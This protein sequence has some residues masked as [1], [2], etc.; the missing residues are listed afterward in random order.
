MA[1]EGLAI[2]MHRS[3]PVGASKLLRRCRA[4]SR[5]RGLWVR[6][7]LPPRPFSPVAQRCWN[8]DLFNEI[9]ACRVW[10]WACIVCVGRRA[11]TQYGGY[12]QHGHR[13]HRGYRASRP[14]SRS[15]YAA[16]AGPP[17][18]S[19]PTP[20][21]STDPCRAVDRRSVLAQRAPPTTCGRRQASTETCNVTVLL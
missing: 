4:R 17:A 15:E 19:A 5:Q 2:Q 13:F 8:V 18:S 11:C 9:K 16:N 3:G 1:R 7:L 14:I 20:T 6:Q 10:H 12:S 21:S